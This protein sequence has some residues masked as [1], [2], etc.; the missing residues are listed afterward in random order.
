MAAELVGSSGHAREKIRLKVPG[1]ELLAAIHEH[2]GGGGRQ[3]ITPDFPEPAGDTRHIAKP[4]RPWRDDAV[5]R[6]VRLRRPGVSGKFS[7]TVPYKR[8]CGVHPCVRHI[9][10]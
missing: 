9:L 7:L 10:T 6:A 4:L 3:R 5:T 8:L 1:V 2:G